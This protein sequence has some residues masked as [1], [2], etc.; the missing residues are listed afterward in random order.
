LLF[1]LNLLIIKFFSFLKP[2]VI[3]H[4]QDDEQDAV[5]PE[6]P[7]PPA[8]RT[9]LEDDADDTCVPEG[10]DVM[11]VPLVLNAVTLGYQ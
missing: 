6:I 3:I 1:L 7:Q 5:V 9:E 11:T 10:K 8:D 2:A 4:S